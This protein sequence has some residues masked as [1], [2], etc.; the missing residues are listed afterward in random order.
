[1]R[2][3]FTTIKSFEEIKK[4]IFPLVLGSNLILVSDTQLNIHKIN[5]PT[6]PHSHKDYQLLYFL[7]GSGI[8]KIE[9]K[10]IKV[11]PGMAILIPPNKTHSFT[12]EI[13][14]ESQIFALRFNIIK[15]VIKKKTIKKEV[16]I[17][18]FLFSKKIFWWF[19]SDDRKSEM[20]NTIR[21]IS[22]IIGRKELGW[23]IEIEGY[24][25]LLFRLFLISFI[26]K[27]K[28][29]MKKISKKEKIFL[30]IQDYIN[31]NLKTK[32]NSCD[33]SKR[34]MISQRYVQKIVKEFT[35]YS[36]T[37]FLN[38]LR[39]EKSK[40]ML[41]NEDL[42]IKYIAHHCGFSNINY[43]TR[44]FKRIEGISPTKYREIL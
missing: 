28:K 8:E 21:K 37:K 30:K 33:I 34:L 32:I 19:L 40:E 3:K 17:M 23:I 39:I 6:Y 15:N 29:K 42:Q 1:M 41:K 9:N 22:D 12:P 20:N 16:K 44:I 5:I 25:Y 10:K 27:K 31:E 43:F 18:K 7:T 11:V 36:F 14:T 35:G 4:E 24:F 13:N 2:Q 26:E 38:I